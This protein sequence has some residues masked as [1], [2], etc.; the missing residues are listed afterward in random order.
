MKSLIYLLGGET[1][2]HINFMQHMLV[3]THPAIFSSVE[4]NIADVSKILTFGN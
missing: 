1:A 3:H 4:G 2:N